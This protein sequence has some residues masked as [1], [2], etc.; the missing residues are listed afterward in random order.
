M[1][2]ILGYLGGGL[3]LLLSWLYSYWRIRNL[4][5]KNKQATQEK[6]FEEIAK[7]SKTEEFRDLA[8]VDKKTDDEIF[9]EWNK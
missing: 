9:K 1:K 8:E 7:N 2:E 4:K 5:A 3:A 6:T